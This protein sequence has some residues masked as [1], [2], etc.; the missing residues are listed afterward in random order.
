MVLIKKQHEICVY[1]VLCTGQC[2]Y[3]L[4]DLCRF[5]KV[6]KYEY[7][8]ETKAREVGWVIREILEVIGKQM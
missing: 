8:K 7:S 4:S 2:I 1:D 5:Y 6:R 3:S